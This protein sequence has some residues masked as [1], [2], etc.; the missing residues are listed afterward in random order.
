MWCCGPLRA[1]VVAE[2]ICAF[3][4]SNKKKVRQDS[5]CSIC[6]DSVDLTYLEGEVV[7]L[8]MLV[9]AETVIPFVIAFVDI[10]LVIFYFKIY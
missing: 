5:P 3:P 4:C 1:N 7:T 8:R 6:I 9:S 2:F 10:F